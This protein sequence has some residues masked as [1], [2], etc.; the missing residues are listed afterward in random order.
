MNIA[1]PGG[2]FKQALVYFSLILHQEIFDDAVGLVEQARDHDF[3]RFGVQSSHPHHEIPAIEP[4]DGGSGGI[5]D[6]RFNRLTSQGIS[7]LFS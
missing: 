6:D 4:F 3:S 2:G 5:G 1:R 7:E